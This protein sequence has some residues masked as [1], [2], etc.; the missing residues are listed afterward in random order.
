MFALIPRH[1]IA[2]FQVLFSLT[3]IYSEQKQQEERSI[4]KAPKITASLILLILSPSSFADV[5]VSDEASFKQKYSENLTRTIEAGKQFVI[6][7]AKLVASGIA[8]EYEAE[9]N[10]NGLANLAARLE[11]GEEERQNLEQLE[12]SQPA[13]GACDTLTLSSD[14]GETACAELN[15]IEQLSKNRAKHYSVA[16]GGGIMNTT[17][18]T[19]VQD[20]NNANNK[21]ATEVMDQCDQ[22]EGSCSDPRLWLSQTALTADEYRALQLQNDIAA[23]VKIAVPQVSGLIPGSPEHARALVQDLR[24]ENTREQNRASLDAI[25]VAQHGTLI[26]GVRAPGRVELYE[27]YDDKH[28]GSKK[29]ICAITNSCTD[30][31]VPPAEAQRQSAEMKAVEIS[32]ALDQYKSNLRSEAL[33][34]SA[35]LNVLNDS[36]PKQ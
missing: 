17:R 29:W 10:N 21:T 26:N 35:L 16:T 23:N 12:R 9:A 6:E 14:L 8:A 4:M 30:S 13:R 36:K 27:Q 3:H 22:L 2:Q 19:D 18:V 25:Q 20:V 24:R 15:Q 33:L 11:K 34:N 32:L 31:Y 7:N 28:S 5:L 1:E